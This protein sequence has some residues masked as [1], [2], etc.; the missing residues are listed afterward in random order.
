[1]KSVAGG[2]SS[3]VVGANPS[4][5][6]APTGISAVWETGLINEE[7]ARVRPSDTVLRTL[8]ADDSIILGNAPVRPTHAYA[9]APA[10]FVTSNTVGIRRPASTGAEF[11]VA[12]T[13]A[14]ESGGLVLYAEGRA[15]DIVHRTGE[16][17]SMSHSNLTASRDDAPQ[18][19]IDSRGMLRTRSIL[20]A[21]EYAPVGDIIQGVRVRVASRVSAQEIRVAFVFDDHVATNDFDCSVAGDVYVTED[22]AA[23]YVKD[24]SVDHG[25]G[26]LVFLW[27]ALVGSSAPLAS[28]LSH[29]ASTSSATTSLRRYRLIAGPNAEGNDADAGAFESESP[30]L[31]GGGHSFL[32]APYSFGFAASTTS[33]KLHDASDGTLVLRCTDDRLFSRSSL[34]TGRAVRIGNV[35]GIYYVTSASPV[36]T[37]SAA[38]PYTYEVTLRSADGR[39]SPHTS[40]EKAFDAFSDAI[41]KGDDVLMPDL[42]P[43][44]VEPYPA[45]LELTQLCVSFHENY[46]M[47]EVRRDVFSEPLHRYLNDISQLSGNYVRGVRFATDPTHTVIPVCAA[48]KDADKVYLETYP[49]GTQTY[50]KLKADGYLDLPTTLSAAS[51]SSTTSWHITCVL[52]GFPFRVT[53]VTSHGAYHLVL[54]GEQFTPRP[55]KRAIRRAKRVASKIRSLGETEMSI[56]DGQK[57]RQWVLC[58]FNQDVNVLTLRRKDGKPLST[59]DLNADPR[60]LYVTPVVVPHPTTMTTD[61]QPAGAVVEST[62]SVGSP[63]TCPPVS[64]AAL[65][66]YGDTYLDGAVRFMHP[67]T[68][69][70][71]PLYFTHD[72]KL[73][74]GSGDG[75]CVLTDSNAT[76]S[77]DVHAGGDVSA[78]RFL[79]AS[80]MRWKKDVVAADAELGDAAAFLTSFARIPVRRFSY[81]SDDDEQCKEKRRRH[82]GVIA[83]ELST[84][85]PDAVSISRRR[86]GLGSERG[87]GN[88]GEAGG[89]ADENSDDVHMVD[90]NEVLFSTVLAVQSLVRRFDHLLS[91]LDIRL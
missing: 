22:D 6:T 26:T 87:T 82:T 25:A 34:M 91:N 23:Y 64:G 79:F 85:L 66:V 48:Y 55:T 88:P 38:P 29:A 14:C 89:F 83:Q 8:N 49:S 40:M 18:L 53:N 65:N 11:D 52:S 31:F 21:G 75:A 77:K 84:L 39:S 37:G 44:A 27:G 71:W 1:M 28:S 43:C 9:Y 30:L 3:N 57:T 41:S 70:V 36:M 2:S 62:L 72:R 51:S 7:F 19:T 33:V 58:H 16:C 4:T 42:V 63:A 5:T 54:H 74:S 80:D 35:L 68:T 46:N 15:R 32:T 45:D 76:F 12:G 24:A 56:S 10:A 47:F 61:A 78:R 50:L 73:V 81:V 60:F 17:I 69:D 67:G 13:M 90:N 20:G 86:F 59:S